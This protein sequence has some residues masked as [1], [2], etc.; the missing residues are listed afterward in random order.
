MKS[1]PF[2]LSAM[3]ALTVGHAENFRVS[4]PYTHENL[5]VF[6]IHGASRAGGKLLTLQ[7]A[8]EQKKVMVYETARVNELAIE[9]LSDD[10]VFIQSGDIVKGGQQDRA[11]GDDFILPSRS[12]K[13]SIGAFCVEHGRWS[14]R[15]GES[16]AGF[17]SSNDRVATKSLKMAVAREKDQGRVWDQVGRAQAMLSAEVAAP[18][19][20]P[21][22]PSSFQLSLENKQL[23]DKT[24]RYLEPLLRLASSKPDVIGYAFAINGKVNSAD[25]YASHELFLKLWPKLLKAS[26]VEAVASLGKARSGQAADAASV[27]AL[28]ANAA[29]GT[30]SRRNVGVRVGV[31]ANESPEI[32][33]LET[34]DRAR[35]DQWVHRS[36]IAK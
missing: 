29:R 27:E 22:S 8:M 9:N 4:G 19:A 25:V 14:R 26:A 20:A 30:A 3:A 16:A 18:V 21:A 17:G 13:L 15:G 1:I 34:Q 23:R 35:K 24:G 7:E 6:L 32:L 31:V 28:L 2:I 5:S 36:Y 12:G 33:Y 10:E 11:L